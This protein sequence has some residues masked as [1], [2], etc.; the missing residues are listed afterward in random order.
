MLARDIEKA[1]RAKIIERFGTIDQSVELGRSVCTFD[2]WKEKGFYIKKGE[3]SFPFKLNGKTR[4]YFWW[5]QVYDFKRW[6]TWK[7]RQKAEEKEMVE[8]GGILV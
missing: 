8:S 7:N 5:T 2:T 4:F 1:L 6:E 3:K